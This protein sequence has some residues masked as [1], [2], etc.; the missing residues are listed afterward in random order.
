M[1]IIC[2]QYLMDIP[3]QVR[4]QLDYI[5]LLKENNPQ[6]QGRLYSNFGSFA[7]TL[8][9]FTDVMTVATEDFGCLVIDNVADQVGY[10]K[11]K[12]PGEFRLF[13][14]SVWK[15]SK[16]HTKENKSHKNHMKSGTVVKL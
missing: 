10:Y 4:T 12:D 11:A 14:S 5:F 13:H 8:Q 7:K 16:A 3:I 6:S 15:F 2:A 9:E 1:I